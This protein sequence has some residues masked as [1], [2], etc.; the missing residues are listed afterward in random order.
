MGVL[1]TNMVVVAYMAYDTLRRHAGSAPNK[2]GP[3]QKLPGWI[4]ES[5]VVSSSFG[6]AFS[7]LHRFVRGMSAQT[8]S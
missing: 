5:L 2:K 6:D 1:F 4:Q 3:L 8:D 7:R